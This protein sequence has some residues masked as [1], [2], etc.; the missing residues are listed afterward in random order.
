MGCYFALLYVFG[1]VA[2]KMILGYLFEG[3]KISI[4]GLHIKEG[5]VFEHLAL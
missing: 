5:S 4:V 3:L 2:G 1:P